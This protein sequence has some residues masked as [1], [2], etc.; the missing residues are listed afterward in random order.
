MKILNFKIITFL[1]GFVSLTNANKE[2]ELTD[3]LFENYNTKIRP[4]NNFSTPVVMKIG[5]N[6]E[7]LEYFNQVSETVDFNIWITMMWKDEY[8][9]WNKSNYNI[10]Y[11][12][13]NTNKIWLPDLELY[14]AAK[15]P[16]VYTI[17]DQATV[18]SDGTVIYK[19]PA[20]FSFLCPL[21]LERFPYDTQTRSMEFGSWKLNSHFLDI[22][23]FSDDDDYK[24]FIINPDFS[25]NEWKI[26]S[27]SI[28]HNYNEYKC[29]PGELWP[30]TKF[31]ISMSR[32][33]EK[34][35]II[36]IMNIILVFTGFII[37]LIKFKIYRRT[38]ILVF[39]PLAIIW[40]I[41]SISYKIPVIGYFS[42]M[43]KILFMSFIVCEIFA[44][45]SGILYALYSEFYLII[46]KCFRYKYYING[47]FK[48]KD[49]NPHLVKKKDFDIEL[50]ELSNQNKKNYIYKKIK[51][52]D[53]V[54]K[55][56]I[57]VIYIILLI[58]F[59]L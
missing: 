2:K 34:Y 6:V 43:Q 3:S 39:I 22:I 44:A 4:V 45:S 17:K 13:V 20:L 31:D 28:Q 1:L 59:F 50:L 10:N 7:S 55:T 36:L 27:H 51:Q 42:T 24:G 25:H 35:N 48:E 57:I 8:L 21:K 52:F 58:I 41:Q 12:N 30:V 11:L 46:E 19:R 56:I 38:Y 37:S 15:L 26:K 16:N 49:K 14:N 54:F 23:P 53:K 47:I 29:C 5:L 18:Y 32:N 9:T 33:S 40:L